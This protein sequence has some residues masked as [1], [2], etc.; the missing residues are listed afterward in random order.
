MLVWCRLTWVFWKGL[1]LGGGQTE[2]GLHLPA[3]WRWCRATRHHSGHRRWS[4]AAA[5]MRL[6]AA[7][8]TDMTKTATY[9]YIS[10]QIRWSLCVLCLFQS[11]IWLKESQ[12]RPFKESQ[13]LSLTPKRWN[14]WN[15]ETTSSTVQQSGYIFKNKGTKTTLLSVRKNS[16]HLLFASRGT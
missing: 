11:N 13:T 4:L 1:S 3:L 8:R 14:R 5:H 7:E 15:H 9:I 10:A 6:P 2:V 12:K 16:Q